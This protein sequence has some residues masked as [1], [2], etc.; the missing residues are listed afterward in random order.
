M[1]EI[2]KNYKIWLQMMMLKMQDVS[3]GFLFQM[4][5]KPFK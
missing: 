2:H 5:I 1:N 3:K 4:D